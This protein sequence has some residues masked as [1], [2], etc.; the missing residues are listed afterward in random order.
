[1][2]QG[3]HSLM[4]FLGR[5]LPGLINFFA[6]AIY[7]RL[8][9]PDEYGKY[10]LVS[11]TVT[12]FN[13]VL[14]QWLRLVLLRFLPNC[15]TEGDQTKLYSSIAVGFVMSSIVSIV[16]ALIYFVLSPAD[17]A[18]SQ[19]LMF[20][21]VLLWFEAFFEVSLEFF[22]SNLKV[23]LYSVAFIIKSFL[24][25]L[26]G[27]C[28]AYLKM[29]AW[30]LIIGI[31]CA[32]LV[33]S[34]FFFKPFILKLVLNIKYLDKS[35]FK[36]MLRY[37][38]PITL[39]YAMTFIINSSDRYF[40]KYY[41]GNAATGM[42]AVGYDLARQSLWVIM[43]SVNL[44]SFPIAVRAFERGGI[45]EAN[46][47]LKA[48]FILLLA[49]SMPAALGLAALADRVAAVFIGKLFT[50][51][52]TLIIPMISIGA[53]VA[54]LKNFYI[55]QSFQLGHKTH[56]QIWSVIAAAIA[57]IIFNILWIPTIGIMGAIYSTLISFA[58]AL[59]VSYIA[60]N[61]SYKMPIPKKEMLKI[62]I[63]SISMGAVLYFLKSYIPGKV[64]LFVLAAIGAVIYFF[65]L[66]G[67]KILEV[68]FKNKKLN[69]KY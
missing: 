39:S 26:V 34:I 64:G 20:G 61:Y 18:L 57:N 55:D 46:V 44:A 37:G 60:S 9:S 12:L 38:M 48:N 17:K 5:G 33:V 42:Y 56:L 27:T 43:T 16:I 30:G 53:F 22:R 59:I 15:K 19:L 14:Y 11:A 58:I 23:M 21:V 51:E 68:D 65:L 1:M 24:A 66:L 54:G 62:A 7:T 29:G 31:L 63:A 67:L 32:D 4:Y 10:A 2:Q 13:T 47:Q 52:V 49:V 3:K 41:M 45:A 50:K 36:M 8:I 28:L 35:Y 69:F 6:V 25:I 40:I